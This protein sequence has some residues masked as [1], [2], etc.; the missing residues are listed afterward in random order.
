LIV[1]YGYVGAAL[2]KELVQQGHNVFGLR[3]SH[4]P[5]ELATHGIV[6]LTGDI[7]NKADLSKLPAAY[8]W[9]VNCVSS[10][11]G[12]TADY[13]AVYLEGTRNLLQWLS[14]SPPRKFVYT[15]STSVY[16]QTDGS[17][18]TEA[19]LTEPAAE[20]SQILLETEK[21]L[22]QAAA[23]SFPA[24]LLR[25]AGIYGPG[26]GHW[27]KQF[28]SGKGTIDGNGERYLNM[29]HRDDVVGAIIAALEKG[30]PGEIYNVVDN[31]PIRQI[32]LF[33]WLSSQFKKPMPPAA[34][35]QQGAE[36]KRGGTNKQ[37]SNAKLKSR[38]SYEFKYPTF[39]EG[40]LA[41]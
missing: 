9:V 13:Q 23:Q 22:S 31:E 20:T 1:G 30:S 18:V 37:I 36:R 25:V 5:E 6:P 4:S 41:A 2:G 21:L 39:R 28:L 26:R 32:D 40:F 10:S 29:V 19:S 35:R 7:T 3:R 17:V 33:Q 8:D 15:S 16:G 14:P 24:V 27:L 12:D 34:E 38:L 11:H